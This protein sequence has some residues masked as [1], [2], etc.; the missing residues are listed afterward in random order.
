MAGLLKGVRGGLTRRWRIA[1][2]WVKAGKPLWWGMVV[3]AT[4]FA[5]PFAVMAVSGIP[6][7]F[8]DGLRWSGLLFQSAGLATVIW[9]LNRS[10]TVFNKSSIWKAILS[11]LGQAWHIVAPREKAPAGT[12]G[13]RQAGTRTARHAGSCCRLCSS[14]LPSARHNKRCVYQ[15][16]PLRPCST[17]G[18]AARYGRARRDS[19]RVA[20]GTAATGNCTPAVPHRCFRKK[21]TS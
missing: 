16:V 2:P 4:L 13:T 19:R 9:G 5:L 11:W 14:W 21:N 12:R 1:R 8:A 3:G 15:A 17:Q 18:E 6:T 10:R 7:D 20:N